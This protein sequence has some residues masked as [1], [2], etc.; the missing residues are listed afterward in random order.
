ML[1]FARTD[2]TTRSERPDDAMIAFAAIEEIAV[3]R[4]DNV[5]PFKPRNEAQIVAETHLRGEIL[6]F[7]QQRV[8][9]APAHCGNIFSSS[10]RNRSRVGEC[11]S[12]TRN[13]RPALRRRPNFRAQ[14]VQI[15]FKRRAIRVLVCAIFCDPF[16]RTQRG[17]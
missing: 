11:V 8:V 2:A 17:S 13:A 6:R 7:A 14:F 4:E 9:N 3:E 12:S 1:S 10:P 16:S 5:G 15:F